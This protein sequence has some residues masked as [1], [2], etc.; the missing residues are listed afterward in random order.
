MVARSQTELPTFVVERIADLKRKVRLDPIV[1]R[2]WTTLLTET[3]R[4]RAAKS[5]KMG[6][7]I[8]D[9]WAKLKNLSAVQAVI[10]IARK[11]NFL[12]PDEDQELLHHLGY[13]SD[14]RGRGRARI[15]PEFGEDGTLRFGD[16]EI[17]VV[18]RRKNKTKPELLLQAFQDAKWVAEI[19]NPFPDTDRQYL[20]NAVRLINEDLVCIRF[21]MRRGGTRVGWTRV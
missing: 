6:P 2:V 9:I 19:D 17:R 10:E 20:D 13:S 1:W 7:D 8:V 16:R 21:K 3:E 14:P 18:P 12:F 5:R 4:Q 11:A 15:K